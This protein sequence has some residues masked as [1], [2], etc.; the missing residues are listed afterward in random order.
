MLRYTES[1]AIQNPILYSVVLVR[2][3]NFRLNASVWRKTGPKVKKRL[4]NQIKNLILM[5]ELAKDN[6]VKL[7]YL[8]R[9]F[10]LGALLWAV[11]S[12]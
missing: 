5:V 10:E 6:I 2:W 1:Y 4:K 3:P 12:P 9:I 11:D 8:L 7:A